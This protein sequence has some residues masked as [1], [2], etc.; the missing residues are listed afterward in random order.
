MRWTP[1]FIAPLLL[2]L[3][4][5]SAD[6]EADSYEVVAASYPPQQIVGGADLPKFFGEILSA[7]HVSKD[8]TAKKVTFY[9]QSH[10][11]KAMLRGCRSRPLDISPTKGV[12]G[13]TLVGAVDGAAGCML[14]DKKAHGAKLTIQTV[15]TVSVDGK[16]VNLGLWAKEKGVEY[17]FLTAV[18]IGPFNAKSAPPSKWLVFA[19]KY[20]IEHG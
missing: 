9:T 4:V 17:D 11:R 5:A 1:F 16:P 6:A 2:G 7:R 19:L 3:S 20:P 10:S 14:A 13:S 18:A 8:T 12:E 15:G